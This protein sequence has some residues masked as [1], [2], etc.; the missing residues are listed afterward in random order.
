MISLTTS[1]LNILSAGLPDKLNSLQYKYALSLRS[2]LS[3]TS[4]ASL[5]T[6]KQSFS[7][8]FD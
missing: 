3:F 1:L 6:F 7:V 8:S 4:V 2:G 5:S